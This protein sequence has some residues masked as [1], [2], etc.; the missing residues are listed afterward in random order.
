V[1]NFT[2]KVYL[3]LG[4]NMPWYIPVISALLIRDLFT[5]VLLKKAVISAGRKQRFFLQFLFAF[6]L[7]SP[8]FLYLGNASA[9][10]IL[11][12]DFFKIF[13]IGMFNA[14]ATMFYWKAI[15]ISLSKTSLFLFLDDVIAITLSLIFLDEYAILNTTIVTGL[16]IGLLSI[17]LFT[18]YYKMPKA[19]SASTHLPAIFFFYVFIH[20]VMH[21]LLLFSLKYLAA[22]GVSKPNF[23]FGW[24]GGALTMAGLA[25]VLSGKNKK[26]N[27][28]EKAFTKKNLKLMVPIGSA[29]VSSLGLA[30]WSFQL[31]PQV[32][33]QPIFFVSQMILPTLV[34]FFYFKEIETID[35]KEKLIFLLGAA[36]ALVIAFSYSA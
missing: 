26:E 5:S 16:A 6:I 13:G 9:D 22:D 33:V 15:D 27:M 23:L 36:G 14:T 35:T 21:G 20:S 30:F 17:I 24:Y 28:T 12:P 29:I 3:K 4:V 31:A 7:V 32:V 11:S 19:N 2:G 18:I 34:G 8:I 25:L 1:V 10:Y